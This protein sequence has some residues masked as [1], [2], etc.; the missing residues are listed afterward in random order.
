[1]PGREPMS[2]RDSRVLS[3]F[4]NP[5]MGKAEARPS[6]ELMPGMSP[7]EGRALRPGIEEDWLE[8]LSMSRPGMEP[9]KGM[10]PERFKRLS[11]PTDTL[12]VRSERIG[13]LASSWPTSE[14]RV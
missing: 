10:D 8:P 2:G 7:N 11:G 9:A 6:I 13:T 4:M 12:L 3:R 5:P 1:M 14:V